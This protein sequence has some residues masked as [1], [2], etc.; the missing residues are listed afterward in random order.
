MA[1]PVIHLRESFS[2]SLTSQRSG[3]ECGCVCVTKE[4]SSEVDMRG[5]CFFVST[6]PFL[7]IVKKL[8]FMA[9]GGLP[10]YPAQ[11]GL[12]LVLSFGPH[13]GPIYSD[14]FKYLS[15]MVGVCYVF[16]NSSP[17]CFGLSVTRSMHWKI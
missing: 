2:L 4:K 16:S 8:L 7:P 15:T 11:C 6:L 5:T 14:I 10:P 17:T 9:H 1:Y 12:F 13:G 3:Q